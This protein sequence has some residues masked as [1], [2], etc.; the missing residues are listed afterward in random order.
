[1]QWDRWG[2][3][4]IIA[5]GLLLL[6]LLLAC[7]Q[8]YAETVASA[9][10]APETVAS[11]AEALEADLPYSSSLRPLLVAAPVSARAKEPRPHALDFALYGAIGG[12]RSL[13]YLSTRHALAGGAR[14]AVLPQ[15]VVSNRGNFI[16]FEG[17]ATSVEVG[18]SIW[19]IRRGQRRLARAMNVFSV[20]MGARTV[21]HNYNMP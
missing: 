13:D 5:C 20:G 12:Y 18:S 6:C 1:M 9:T 11:G 3:W 19:L 15:W 2:R 14:E 4:T 7:G 10:S 8:G 16:A 21:V 17:L